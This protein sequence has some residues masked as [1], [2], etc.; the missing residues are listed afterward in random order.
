MV[1]LNKN[2]FDNS[3]QIFAFQNTTCEE[4]EVTQIA[5]STKKLTQDGSRCYCFAQD[6]A[7]ADDAVEVP[8]SKGDEFQIRDDRRTS[9]DVD[10]RLCQSTTFV[11]TQSFQVG[12]VFHGSCNKFVGV[13][14]S[15]KRQARQVA[16]SFGDERSCEGRDRKIKATIA[17]IIGETNVS[18]DGRIAR[19]LA[20]VLAD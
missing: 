12:A 1:F 6:A 20:E 5:S 19:Q 16:M 2:L 18:P 8:T 7:N 15:E 3:H 13:V 4:I 14:S 10:S 11:D 9:Q 17:E